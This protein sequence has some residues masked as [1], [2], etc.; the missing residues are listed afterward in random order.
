MRDFFKQ[1][2][3]RTYEIFGVNQL[4]KMDDG[5]IKFLLDALENV[6][7]LYN[8]IDHENQKK[9]INKRMVTDREYRNINARLIAGWFN[10]DGKVFFQQEAHIPSE[11]QPEPVE[12]EERERW[13]NIW[14]QTLRQVEQT[15][16]SQRVKGNGA[17]MREQLDE[18][19]VK[20]DEEKNKQFEEAQKELPPKNPN[21][22][23]VKSFI[24][25]GI[26][27]YAADEGEAMMLYKQN[28]VQDSV[29]DTKPQ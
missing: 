6:S 23:P 16:P 18:A 28:F 5:Q 15:F 17:K 9:I 29:T 2:L 27:I 19:G 26:E 1:I 3:S 7:T 20:F 11:N 14:E 21:N 13:L 22:N 12:G 10:L 24:I 25:E 8:Y 4:E